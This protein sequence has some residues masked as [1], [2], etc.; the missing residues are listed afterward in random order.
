MKKITNILV[1]L[2]FASSL[3]FTSA[4]QAGE[5][6]VTGGA[7]AT[8]K[9]GGRSQHTG[10]QVGVA[11]ELDFSASGELDNGMTWSYQTQL[12]GGAS[13]AFTDDSQLTISGG[14]GTIGFFAT[15]G[16]LSVEEPSVGAL[17]S[18]IGYADT[19][20]GWKRGYDVDGYG[21][22]QYHLPSGILPLGGAVKVGYVPTMQNTLAN[23]A[24]DNQAIAA[25]E[26][27]GRALTMV[28][29]GLTPIDG[30]SVKGDYAYTS[31]A[32]GETS[33]NASTKGEQG[34]SGNVNLAYATGPFKFGY[35]QGAHQPGVASGE[36]TIYYE[37]RAYGISF[38]LN[39]N[40]VISYNNDESE[41]TELDLAATGT[42]K[43]KTSVTM[44]ADTYQIAYTMGGMTL[45]YS[46]SETSNTGY[47]SGTGKTTNVNI[48]SVAMSF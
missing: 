33:T 38:A 17:G 32:N 10:T 48:L 1:G 2:L 5:L 37:N 29:V 11:N 12:D 13:S 45:G 25:V 8:V 22:F 46:M 44:E 14:F 9:K 19:L 34:S 23:S 16:G 7:V 39:E 28:Q 24:K 30:L 35:T 15:E 3:A 4:V 42:T 47:S 41:K 6:T 31:G 43:T 21:N 20:D 40:V 27:V 18:G 26:D 36:N